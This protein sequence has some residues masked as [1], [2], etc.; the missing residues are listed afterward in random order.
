MIAEPI[1]PSDYFTPEE[2]KNK[3]TVN[4]LNTILSDKINE[5]Q[6]LGEKYIRKSKK[7]QKN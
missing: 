3:E 5:L 7:S 6:K 1:I 4:K 2:M